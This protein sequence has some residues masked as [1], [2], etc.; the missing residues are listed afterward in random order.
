MARSGSIQVEYTHWT[1]LE[2]QEATFVD[3]SS[4]SQPPGVASLIEP[5][6]PLAPATLLPLEVKV[7][8]RTE[9][10]PNFRET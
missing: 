4:A 6:F 2:A 5:A 7:R 3:R 1:A 9:R 10:G 8:E